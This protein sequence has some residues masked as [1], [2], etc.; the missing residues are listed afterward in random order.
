M[1]YS[2][3]T[4]EILTALLGIGVLLADLWL[5]SSA[6]KLLGYAAATGTGILLTYAIGSGAPPDG[7]D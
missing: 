5:P 1:N 7:T 2:L 4:L 3:L 6:R